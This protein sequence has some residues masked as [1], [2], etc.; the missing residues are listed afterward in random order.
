MLPRSATILVFAFSLVLTVPPGSLLAQ[1]EREPGWY[2]EAE[3]S[4]VLTAGNTSSSAFGVDN[5]LERLFASSRLVLHVGGIRVKGGDVDRVAIGD[6]EDFQIVEVGDPSV[7]AENYFADLR[8]DRDLSDRTYAYGSGG[9][10]RNRFAGIRNRW[11]GAAGVGRTLLQTEAT[12]F[13][14]DLGATITTEE[15]VVGATESFGG[16]RLTTDLEHQLTEST[17]LT[18][19][20]IVDENLSDTE[21]LRAEFINGIA[22]D[23]SNVLALKT[24]LKLNYDNQPALEEVPLIA[25][26]GEPPAATVLAP[27]DELDTQVTVAL[28]VAF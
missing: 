9:W 12:T 22:V 20:L 10:T 25:A 19:T 7:T 28:V 23:I 24:G 27:L 18:S 3:L 8:F 16:L 2:D 14:A 4:I 17:N 13:R 15:P 1:D 6:A 21:D 26:P 5:E 11:I